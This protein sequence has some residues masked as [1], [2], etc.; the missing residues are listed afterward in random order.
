MPVSILSFQ[1]ILCLAVVAVAAACHKPVPEPDAV[2]LPAELKAYTLFEPG[3]HWIYR[4][5]AT[6]RLDSVWVVSTEKE[7]LRMG[8]GGTSDRVALKYEAFTV[9][10]NSLIGGNFYYTILRECG[11]PYRENQSTK[12]PCWVLERG[13]YLPNSTADEGSELVFPYRIDK[14]KPTFLVAYAAVM[15]PYWYSQPVVLNGTSY[16]GLLQVKLTA[17]ASED[18]WPTHYYWVPGQGVVLRRINRNGR[19]QTWQL[20]RSHIVQ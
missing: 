11:L 14:D 16:A 6:Q 8:S 3:T 13:R 19:W 10:T 4:D 20:V 9:R 5:S 1:R 18:G 7:I 15:Y 17:D 2:P 12:G